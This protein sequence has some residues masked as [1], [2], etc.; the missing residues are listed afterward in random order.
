M[1]IFH[2]RRK[3]WVT[4]WLLVLLAGVY[5][6][7]LPGSPAVCKAAVA[8]S[9]DSATQG[10]QHDSDQNPSKNNKDGSVATDPLEQ[11]EKTDQYVVSYQLTQSDLKQMK[12]TDEIIGKL[13]ALKG[14]TF[15]T[16]NEFV[17]AALKAVAPLT[18]LFDQYRAQIV[19]LAQ[20]PDAYELTE[21]AIPALKK[22][23]L[24]DSLLAD[25][26]N[27]QNK[28]Y[29]DQSAFLTALQ[30]LL[31]NLS[32]QIRQYQAAV[33]QAAKVPRTYSL[34]EQSLSEL[35]TEKIPPGVFEKLDALQDK[36]FADKDEFTQA[37]RQI[38]EDVTVEY[39]FPDDI[40][41]EFSNLKSKGLESQ[42]E[43]AAKILQKTT[44][45]YDQYQPLILKSVEMVPGYLLTE[46]AY[47]KLG[48]EGVP[49]YIIAKLRDLE[50]KGYSSE[51]LFKA[52][53]KAEIDTWQNQNQ[54]LILKYAEKLK[55]YQLSG[56]SLK[57]F[58]DELKSKTI[59]DDVIAKLSGLL[60][61]EYASQALYNS[62]V[63]VALGTS[64]TPAP[65]DEKKIISSARKTHRFDAFQTQPVLWS[66]GDCGCVSDLTGQVYGFYPFWMVGNK[67]GDPAANKA[68]DVPK[69]GAGAQEQE[70]AKD[71]PQ[72]NP[73]M[74]DFSVL[75]RVGYYTIPVDEQG[76]I[77]DKIA[78]LKEQEADFIKIAQKFRTK[79]DIVLYNNHWQTW[80]Q[81]AAGKR[82][83]AINDTFA[84]N[85]ADW[86]RYKDYDLT[87]RLKYKIPGQRPAMV[88]GV[89]ID[90][91]PYLLDGNSIDLFN[92]FVK[93]LYSRLN[94]DGKDYYL[95]LLLPMDALGQGVY[96]LDNLV[97]LDPYIDLLLIFIGE[98][99]TES[100]KTLRRNIEDVLLGNDRVKILR[101]IVP[102]ISPAGIG[103]EQLVDD[104]IYFRDN[105]GGVG[106]W[107]LPLNSGKSA[108]S[109]NSS[110]KNQFQ[111]QGPT[112][113]V[114][115]LFGVVCDAQC[116][117][118]IVIY[119]VWDILIFLIV[120]YGLLAARM[121]ALRA[122]FSK[123]KPFFL[124][125]CFLTILFISMIFICDP[126]YEQRQGMLILL[127]FV[128]VYFIWEYV[129]KVKLAD[130][131]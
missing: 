98:P 69:K 108:A 51:T 96:Q 26:Q 120:V 12:A 21:N 78:W 29:P 100:K 57:K 113:T 90:S 130:K 110:L 66:G 23:N 80:C 1:K 54:Q 122:I 89:T 84:T 6:V 105:F 97:K 72:A 25:L 36:P 52:A 16:E 131:P 31:N 71:K 83:L 87:E 46:Q 93:K 75:S 73:Q 2:V 117:Y 116:R 47:T 67:T 15:D 60:G 104:L 129:R 94:S 45:Q 3:K 76:N 95:N 74:I 59:P 102:V 121:C 49:D 24:P 28:K 81:Q 35:K 101:K 119:Y 77:E 42:R 65:Y 41:S 79:V 118:R 85:I 112:Q 126:A 111:K 115:K 86:V 20:G 14:K 34:T 124:A 103:E 43:D 27:L 109:I 88:N 32:N 39:N 70:K 61:V 38:I 18:A 58:Q 64:A 30:P 106:L 53:L 5:Q 114:D 37:V 13:E 68:G 4:C 22:E 127:L 56:P 107:P 92:D 63:K 128:I 33:I 40:L 50:N 82:G 10:A 8:A 99:T 62:A 9:E 17:E 11:A 7:I 55:T 48:N 91:D 125:Y 44:E 19:K 123:Y